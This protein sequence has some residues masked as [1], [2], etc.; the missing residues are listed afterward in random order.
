MRHQCSHPAE[1]PRPDCPP[2]DGRSE[3]SQPLHLYRLASCGVKEQRHLEL[4]QGV[5]HLAGVH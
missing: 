3:R 2:V 5:A 1:S 4:T